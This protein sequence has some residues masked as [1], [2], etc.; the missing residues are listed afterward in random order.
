MGKSNLQALDALREIGQE[1]HDV[2]DKLL[3][4][5]TGDPTM[6]SYAHVKVKDEPA[7]C[8]L[9]MKRFLCLQP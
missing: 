8:L 6:L 7:V 4:G 1:L 5:L 3:G 2:R 9:C